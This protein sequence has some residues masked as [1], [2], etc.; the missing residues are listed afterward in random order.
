MYRS[1][2]SQV[3][4]WMDILVELYSFVT[5]AHTWCV[6]FCGKLNAEDI[7]FIASSFRYFGEIGSA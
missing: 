2:L 5:I 1:N 4:A 6:S 3:A 7:P